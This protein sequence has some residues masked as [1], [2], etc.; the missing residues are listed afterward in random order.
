[1]TASQSSPEPHNGANFEELL[2]VMP[3]IAEV[4]NGFTSEG[5]QRTALSALLRA[6]GSRRSPPLTPSRQSQAFRL[7]GH[8]TAASPKI[9]AARARADHAWRSARQWPAAE[10]QEDVAPCQGHQPAPRGQA[11][12]A[13]L[14]G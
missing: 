10:P 1:M 11:Q 5:N 9:T 12:S 13:G 2:A 4:V 14:R 7:Y 3:R 6:F 8:W